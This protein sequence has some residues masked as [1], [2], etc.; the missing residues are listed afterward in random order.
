MCAYLRRGREVGSLPLALL[1]VIIVAGLV[2]VLVA[3]I[4]ATQN[5]VRFDESFHGSLPVADAGTNLGKF[6][7]NNG[8]ELQATGDDPACDGSYPPTDFPIGCSTPPETREID[9]SEYTFSLTRTT[10]RDWEIT[11]TGTD[12]RW[13]EQRRVVATLRERPLV[14]VALF[15]ETFI[16][17]GGSNSVDSYTS[18]V[19]VNIEDSWCTGFGF[20]ATNGDFDS[21]GVAGSDCHPDTYQRTV[22]RVMLH[23][24]DENPGENVTD[25]KPGGDRCRH[26]GFDDANCKT[27]SEDFP[28]LAAETFDDKLKLATDEAVAFIDAALLA[29]DEAEVTHEG[30]YTVGSTLQPGTFDPDNVEFPG[31]LD[32]PFRCVDYL[33]FDVDAK[34][35]TTSD[36]PIIIVS[37]DGMGTKGQGGGPGG[38]A[39]VGCEDAGGNATA[40]VAGDPSGGGASRPDARRLWIFTNGDVTLRGHSAVA[41]VIWA[42]QA[43]CIMQQQGDIFGSLLC[44]HFEKNA[45]GGWRFHYDEALANIS[46]GEFYTSAWREEFITD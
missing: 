35:E 33:Y 39:H 10:S 5:Q 15:A 2:T 1:A 8:T 29:C 32:G 30:T 17:M 43:K 37:R 4:V 18:D 41:G 27:I 45:L 40:C 20:V 44:E 46:S 28:Y 36:E 21:S 14:D 23:D 42:P 11:S 16:G 3:R 22:D 38:P 13:G 19:A 24:W 9:G 31:D 34:L 6:W 26:A 12:E 7:L 25:E